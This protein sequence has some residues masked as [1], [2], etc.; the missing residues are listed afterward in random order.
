MVILAIN[1]NRKELYGK[2][3]LEF[4]SSGSTTCLFVILNICGLS[5]AV[6]HAVML[7]EIMYCHDN[8]TLNDDHAVNS[9]TL[10]QLVAKC[11][12]SIIHTLWEHYTYPA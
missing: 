11:G 5:K 4:N 7:G 6:N 2:E 1:T 3:I 12:Y 9:Q 8:G 10:M